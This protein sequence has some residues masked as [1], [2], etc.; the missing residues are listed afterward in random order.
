MDIIRFVQSVI[1]NKSDFLAIIN[2]CETIR[3]VLERA[4][5]G[6]GENFLRGSL[7]DALSQLNMRVKSN[8]FTVGWT[9]ETNDRVEQ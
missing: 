3:R 8:K 9:P 5:S 2:K 4:T 1:K 6:A 7:G